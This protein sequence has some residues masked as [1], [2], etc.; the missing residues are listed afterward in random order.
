LLPQAVWAS[1]TTAINSLAVIDIN[2]P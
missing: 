1:T 2:M